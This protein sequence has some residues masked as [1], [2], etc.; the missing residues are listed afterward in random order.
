MTYRKAKTHRINSKG[1]IVKLCFCLFFAIC[2]FIAYETITIARTKKS[3]AEQVTIAFNASDKAQARAQIAKDSIILLQDKTEKANEG[4]TLAQI[5]AQTAMESA[6]KAQEDAQNA[7]ELANQ[8]Q[9]DAQNAPEEDGKA[10]ALAQATLTASNAAE[11]QE[12]AQAAVE[13]ANLALHY[14]NLAVEASANANSQSEAANQESVNADETATQAVKA[15]TS[16]QENFDSF[17]NVK[18]SSK[19]KLIFKTVEELANTSVAKTDEVLNSIINIEDYIKNSSQYV[20]ESENMTSSVSEEILKV[21]LGVEATAKKVSETEDAFQSTKTLVAKA[22]SQARAKQVRTSSGSGLTKSKGVVYFN[23]HRE[24]WYSERVL[25]GTG[26][27][28]P[29]RHTDEAGIIRDGDGYICVASMDYPKGTVIE[30]S[31]GTGKVYD[32]CG[33]SGT[34]DIYTSW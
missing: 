23:G 5:E 21:K 8:A 30:T 29:G 4:A 33:V 25:P 31:L 20:S 7:V 2:I 14:A 18:S 28:I 19:A 13:A 6:L 32:V 27:N 26:L 15:S 17:V 9:L 3:T 22:E 12:Q 34:I 10:D 11:S 1:I 16:A 24:T